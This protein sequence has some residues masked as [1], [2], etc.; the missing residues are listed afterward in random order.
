MNTYYY[1]KFPSPIGTITAVA[2]STAIVYIS[3]GEK[4]LTDPR[5]HAFN[6]KAT[7]NPL[8][9]TLQECLFDAPSL[10]PLNPKGT[11][12]QQAV[13]QA[14]RTIPK[15]KTACYADIAQKIGNPKAVRAVG[16]ACGA[17]PLA[18]V[19][20]CHRIVHK[21][22]KLSGYSWGVAVQEQLLAME[23]VIKQ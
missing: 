20:P 3:I 23:S 14:L 4:A 15:G 1:T 19:I 17:N 13:W 10:L 9:V 2:D 7:T 16:G 12:F 8:L 21:N 5:F 11:A 22:G 6:A 18:I